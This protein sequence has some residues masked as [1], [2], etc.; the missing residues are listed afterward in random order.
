MPLAYALGF[1]I[2]GASVGSFI[3]VIAYR[4]PLGM[5]LLA[6]PSTCPKC[7]GLIYGLDN[8]PI[9]GWLQL[10][11]KCRKCKQPI[12]LRYPAVE[13]GCGL[14]WAAVGWADAANEFG[15]AQNVGVATTHALFVSALLAAALIDYDYQIIP[16][17]ISLGGLVA[18]LAVSGAVP[19]L[20]IQ[21]QPELTA[22]FMSAPKWAQGLLGAFSGALAGGALLYALSLFG[23]LLFRARIKKA[24][25]DD[26]DIT[27]AI[28]LGDVKLMAFAGA[29]LGWKAVLA[30][31][32]VGTLVGAVA[33][34]VEKF[35]KG[36]WPAAGEEVKPEFFMEKT[37]MEFA[38]LPEK[39]RTALVCRWQTGESIMPY[40]PALAAGCF[41]LLVLRE[42]VLRGVAAA[43]IR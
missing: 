8:I 12:S 5:T 11:G 24:Q 29:V 16:D 26:P 3:N 43:I 34:L 22:A 4:L 10:G 18:A 42:P 33:G 20:H 32:F 38:P 13:F 39:W 25:R 41:I 1:F 21:H 23:T 27:S 17:E 2:V 28:G 35:G 31:F 14:L 9:F 6:P 30:G 40:G 7:G 37:F 36:R 19:Q 15:A